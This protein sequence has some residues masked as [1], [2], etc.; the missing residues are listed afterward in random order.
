MGAL[1]IVKARPCNEPDSTFGRNLHQPSPRLLD[2]KPD[3]DPRQQTDADPGNHFEWTIAHLLSRHRGDG[4]AQQAC[5][6]HCKQD[7]CDLQHDVSDKNTACD[8]ACPIRLFMCF[9][10]SQA[11]CDKSEKQ[12][13]D[14]QF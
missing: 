10:R 3:P 13:D 8:L 1:L 12:K 14:P 5:Q 2:D 4:S 6:R 11:G 7:A 9:K